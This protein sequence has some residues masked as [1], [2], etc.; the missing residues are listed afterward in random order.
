MKSIWKHLQGTAAVKLQGAEPEELLE[1]CRAAGLK[2]WNVLP[3]DG[4]TLHLELWQRDLKLLADMAQRSGFS[5]E[6]LQ[7]FGGS[8][9]KRLLTRRKGLLIGLALAFLLLFASSL[10]VWQVQVSGCDRV[11]TGEVLRALAASGVE[12][13]RFI[14]GIDR[15]LVRNQ[16]LLQLPELEWLAVNISG[17]RAAV[18][19][20][21]RE[22]RPEILSEQAKTEL[23]AVRSG[24]VRQTTVLSGRSLVE[25]GDAVLEGEVLISGEREDLTGE[26]LREPA[27]GEVRAETWYELSSV[28]PL[29]MLQT[30]EKG[31]TNAAFSLQIGKMRLNIWPSSRK[32]LDEC[33][34]IVHEY[35]L[36]IKGL[37]STPLRLLSTR[38][39]LL[40]SGIG[41][42]DR[43]EEMKAALL[44]M[45]EQRSEVEILE[46]T[47][48]V[49]RSG[50][51]LVVTLRARCMENIA[52]FG[53]E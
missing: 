53:E 12:P 2:L 24:I 16:V 44:R 4:C 33:D 38:R 21:E 5:L 28:C 6:I 19:V 29:E 37:F 17:S 20:R 3:V 34:K 23:R 36:G 18:L 14:P 25:P 52:G 32:G 41:P 42:A 45:L 15:E 9:Y 48:S 7:L 40:V 22:E 39:S 50:G 1:R 46:H 49:G 47:F 13:G 43:E 30:R 35:T 26:L 51:L 27:L 8:R 11:S 31:R 10:F